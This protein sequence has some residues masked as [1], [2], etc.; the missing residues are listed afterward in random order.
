[1]ASGIDYRALA[2]FRYEIRR[3]VTFSEQA[4]RSRNVEPQQHQALLAIKGLPREVTVTIGVLAERLQIQHHSAVE[5]SDRMETRGFIR[6]SRSQS[7]KR[8]VLLQ[9]TARGERLLHHLSLAHRAEL[10]T[11]GPRLIEAL[12]AA[13]HHVKRA[14]PLTGLHKGAPRKPRIRR[15]GVGANS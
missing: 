2:D 7:D 15:V 9:L 11:A 5:L 4:V 1:M 3:F 13:I 12:E 14:S 8:E 10:R 6:R